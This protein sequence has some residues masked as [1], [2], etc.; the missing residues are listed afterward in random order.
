MK[1][2]RRKWLIVTAVVAAILASL[3]YIVLR[4][5]P[6]YVAAAEMLPKVK[7]QAERT[8]GP[9]T[10]DEHRDQSGTVYRDDRNGWR[11][12]SQSTPPAASALWDFRNPSSDT[13]LQ[14]FLAEQAWFAELP[15]R[16]APL[17]V[18][19][20][21]KPDWKDWTFESAAYTKEMTKAIAVA[22]AATADLGR[23]SE[24]RS[25]VQSGHG[26]A[27]KNYEEPSHLN[28][29]VGI[30]NQS[31]LTDAIL[32]TA[33]K[34]RNSPSVFKALDEL[35]GEAPEFPSVS[36]L[37]AA[38]VRSWAPYLE[39]L[40]GLKP[41]EVEIWL[42]QM[43][44]GAFEEYKPKSLLDKI[45]EHYEAYKYGG[46]VEVRRTGANTAAA[47]EARFWEAALA[48]DGALNGVSAETGEGID[49]LDQAVDAIGNATD[50]S[51]E[52]AGMFVYLTNITTVMQRWAFR[53]AGADTVMEMVKRF[54]EYDDIP[55]G[56]PLDL[57]FTD[58]FGH[59]APVL[60]RKTTTGFLIYSRD[61][62][63]ADDGYVPGNLAHL[64]KRYCTY[65]RSL[66][67]KD[68]GYVV[69]YAPTDPRK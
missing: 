51:Y 26:I 50:P 53:V 36:K 56:L 11:D 65:S 69:S 42:D 35:L 61:A 43:Q 25:F 4:E 2:K 16:L 10:W 9:L 64:N 3:F 1:K 62:D 47:L 19:H 28:A 67:G 12:L 24:L 46:E 55:V 60:Y 37:V 44:A 23:V 15:L 32:R 21:F 13:G 14:V 30:A 66:S 29:L 20:V 40:R 8:F 57:V 38:E 31:V 41:G 17:R 22:V 59:G 52:M 33:V 54:P 45:K 63:E 34:H 48:L 58:P 68:V 6:R 49:E 5:D 7:A 27:V 39:D 18:H